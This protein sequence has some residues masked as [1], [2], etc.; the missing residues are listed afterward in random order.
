VQRRVRLPQ[1]GGSVERHR[2]TVPELDQRAC[3]RS[4]DVRGRPPG[5]VIQPFRRVRG[6]TG[7]SGN[8]YDPFVARLCGKGGRTRSRALSVT[9]KRESENNRLRVCTRPVERIL[10]GYAHSGRRRARWR[11]DCGVMLAACARG[12]IARSLGPQPIDALAGA[13]RVSGMRK[14]RGGCE[15]PLLARL[16]A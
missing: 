15:G 13:Q 11:C 8:P 16:R 9:K 2:L 14:S 3:I 4:S 6:G 7:R 12:R 1:A 5:A 10:P